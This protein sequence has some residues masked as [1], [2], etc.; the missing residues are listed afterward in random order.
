[1]DG[2]PLR[3]ACPVMKNFIARLG[4]LLT[5]GLIFMAFI[6]WRMKRGHETRNA[7]VFMADVSKQGGQQAL[8]GVMMVLLGMR[9]SHDVYSPLA[10]YGALFPFEIVLTTSFTWTFRQLTEA[11]ARKHSALRLLQP[12]AYVGQ[13][14]PAGKGD[15][16][17]SWYL[18]Q[19]LQATLLIGFP[20]RV[21]ALSII[22]LSLWLLPA[23]LSPCAGLAR[24]YYYSGLTCS[25][26]VAGLVR[27]RSPRRPARP[28]SCAAGCT[29]SATYSARHL[30]QAIFILYILPV[31]G[32]ATQ[33]IVIDRLQVP[34][35]RRS[36]L[37]SPCAEP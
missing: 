22:A 18:A 16:R 15:W 23:G 24:F 37:R 13:Y 28:F 30:S 3:E 7:R 33:F 4:I 25:Q 32:D 34:P 26:Q 35:L 2:A 12:L 10:W 14:G 29:T 6:G 17:W 1:M 31:F 5:A 9:L 21:C 27:R 11:W 19:L 8:G 20:A 36:V